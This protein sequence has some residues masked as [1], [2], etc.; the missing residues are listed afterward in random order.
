MRNAQDELATSHEDLVLKLDKQVLLNDV[1]ACGRT[2]IIAKG[3][4]KGR[5]AVTCAD[6][7]AIEVKEELKLCKSAGIAAKN[8]DKR[9]A[10]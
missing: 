3:T 7:L 6:C 4:K 1:V 8:I 9:T 2:I 10:P 5:N